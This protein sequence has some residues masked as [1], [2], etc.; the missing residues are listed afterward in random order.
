[1]T[2]VEG[3]VAPFVFALG[4]NAVTSASFTPT[5]GSLLMAV[6]SNSNGS[7][8]SPSALVITDTS[9]FGSW[10]K[11]VQHPAQNSAPWSDCSVWVK[12]VG[13][14]PVAMTVTATSGGVASSSVGLE[15]RQFIGAQPAALQ[16]GATLI[17]TTQ[18]E[19]CQFTASTS[20]SQVVAAF[21]D[22]GDPVSWTPNAAT[23]I[24]GQATGSAGDSLVLME[25]TVLSTAG[26]SITLGFTNVGDP[27]FP[28]VFAVAEIL[29]LPP[30]DP[31]AGNFNDAAIASVLDKIVSY[32]L[33]SGR[34]DAVNQH[35][36]KSAPGNQV[37]FAV[38]VQ[39]IKPL[40]RASGLS[41]TSG[42]IL[43]T[44]RIYQNFR[45]QPF[46]MIDPTVTAAC[47]DMMGALSAD[48]NFGGVGGVRSLDL[49]GMYGPSLSAA[50][51]YVEIDKTVY[52]VMTIQ[53][54]VIINDM[55][56]QVA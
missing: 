18:S 22:A 6:A 17:Q 50:A 44:G 1:M 23:S 48:F 29:P 33:T 19:T 30:V 9:G 16:T 45:S 10:K 35:E 37:T 46:D 56:V 27:N 24:Y 38:W 14:S 28:V 36:P 5:A 54:P 2:L 51:G 53:I 13:A 52:R 3:V 4:G 40:P 34:F 49:L 41:S 12:D 26:H 25:S 42:T 11:L 21:G 20:G 43:F 7:A 15:V 31:K 55:F 32:A 8:T 39:S 47:T